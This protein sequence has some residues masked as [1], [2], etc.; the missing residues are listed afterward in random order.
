[1][2]ETC[3]EVWFFVGDDSVFIRAWADSEDEAIDDAE[4]QLLNAGYS[5]D[6]LELHTIRKVG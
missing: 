2:G 3:Y 4:G 6:E 5:E 1:M